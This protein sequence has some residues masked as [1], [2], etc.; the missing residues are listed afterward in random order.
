MDTRILLVICF[1]LFF[2]VLFLLQQIMGKCTE[3]IIPG[4]WTVSDQFKEEA[5]ID[6]L[7]LYFDDG[8]GYDYGGYMVMTV[9]GE[10]LFNET[11]RFRVIPK[12]YFK[13]DDYELIMEKDTKVMP[14]KVTMTLCPDSGLMELKCLNKKKIYAKLYKDNQMSAKTIL[15]IGDKNTE[16]SETV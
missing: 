6:Q 11:M 5:H 3:K 14:Q 4:F 2:I 1:V 8:D 9:D 13:S 16:D 15:K 12:G 10:T 7:I